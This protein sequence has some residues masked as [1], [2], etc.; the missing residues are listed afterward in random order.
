MKTLIQT[1]F[2][3]L[4][5]TQI[6]FGQWVWTKF[7]GNPV[8]TGSG[9]S[10]WDKYVMGPWVIFNAD[11]NRYEMFFFGV[12]NNDLSPPFNIGIAYSTDKINW[13][14]HQ[15]P[16]I[17]P[18][19]GFWDAIAAYHPCVIREDSIYKMWYMALKDDYSTVRICYAISTDG[20]MM[21]T[22]HPNPVFT[23]GTAEWESRAIAV[24]LVLKETEGYVMYYT[25]C[26]SAG[27][28]TKVG[29]AISTDGINWQRDTVH[30]P[31]LT[32]GSGWEAK[33][34]A[35]GIVKV[36]DM[37]YL[38][39][40]GYS[41]P[42]PGGTGGLALSSD[43]GLTF[44]KYTNNPVI[45]RSSSGWDSYFLETGW[46][47]YEDSSFYWWY[48]GSP[49][50]YQVQIGLATSP[51]E[52]V[53]V[54]NE[55]TQPT[56]FALEQNYPN[57]FNPSTVISYQLPVSGD[58]TLKVYDIL[59]NE[60]ATLVNEYKTAGKYEVEFSIYSDKGQNLSSGIYFYKLQT[61]EYTA[62]NKMVLLR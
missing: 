4:L 39:Y 58:V 46:V 40:D 50:F 16:I 20:G 7:E 14:K 41:F 30:S 61:G 42:S 28:Y 18:T 3:F 21:W 23:P 17:S 62:V 8:L 19:P 15:D 2:F 49:N 25:G 51:I 35:S 44:Q 5:T 1:L 32:A 54:G 57:P 34:F 52:P 33:I 10:T 22:K 26:N 53:S 56:E 43:G 9:S 24:P 13:T 6:C 12:P 55:P 37:Y 45:S 47:I 31:V 60:V 11:S 36:D 29:R 38:F 48:V 27:I 59:G